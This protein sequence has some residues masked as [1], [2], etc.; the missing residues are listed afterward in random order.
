VPK[1]SDYYLGEK[2]KKGGGIVRGLEK[3]AGGWRGSE[4]SW[5]PWERDTTFERK[6]G[7]EFPPLRE[8]NKK[9]LEK[10]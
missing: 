3:S 5:R 1:S 9:L 10:G 4:E 7:T 8:E 2:K 6:K